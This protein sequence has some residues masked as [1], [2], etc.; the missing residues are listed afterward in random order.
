MQGFPSNMKN[1]SGLLLSICLFSVVHVGTAGTWQSMV[2]DQLIATNMVTHAAILGHDGSTW[3]SSK[4]FTVSLQ[5]GQTILSNFGN[6]DAMQ[7]N[8]ITVNEVK[9]MYFSSTDKVI[10]AK[11]G[12]W[13]VHIFKTNQALLIGVY[14]DPIVPEQ[15]ATVIEKLGDYLISTGY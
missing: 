5:E 1:I 9:Y 13:G 10:R 8:G 2:E 4:D 14:E 15:A 3:G 11:K 12:T 7:Q 6:T